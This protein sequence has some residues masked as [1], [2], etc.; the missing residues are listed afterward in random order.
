MRISRIVSTYSLKG[1]GRMIKLQDSLRHKHLY[2]LS[3]ARHIWSWLVLRDRKVRVTMARSV[4]TEKA[5]LGT[6]MESVIIRS[7]KF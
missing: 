6:I 1:D 7:L 3:K 4:A 5:D 2:V